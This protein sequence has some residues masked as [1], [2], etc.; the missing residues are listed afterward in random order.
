MTSPGKAELR[1]E[2]NAR[3]RATPSDLAEGAA[4]RAAE[5][6]AQL[7]GDGR[8]AVYAP[9]PGRGELDPT[10]LARTL[11]ARG[12]LLA[13]PRVVSPSEPLAFHVATVADL[14]P[15][16]WEI[17]EPGAASAAIPLEQ[18]DAFVVPL[19]AFDDHGGR[20]GWGAGHYDRTLKQAPQA[21]RVG[22]A[23]AFQHAS[24]I[25]TTAMDE[26]LDVVVTEEGVLRTT[27]ARQR[28]LG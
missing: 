27:A 25:P 9:I 13:Y 16:N 7:L 11:A 23:F 26:P 2:M 19:L 6:A 4:V 14:A 18:I 20:V 22:F 15:G 24:L 10:P 21:L 5:H 28:R 3:R 17:P 1:R 12:A 8:I